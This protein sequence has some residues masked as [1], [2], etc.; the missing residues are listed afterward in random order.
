M[1]GLADQHAKRLLERKIRKSRWALLCERVWPRLWLPIGVIGIF[2]L[3]SLFGVW[4]LLPGWGHKTLLAFF[5]V[6]LLTSLFPLVALPWPSRKEA[7]RRLELKSN[8]KHRPVS[9]YEDSLAG[10]MV[11]HTT[12]RIWKIH[13]ARLLSIFSKLKSGWPRPKTERYDP[14]ALRVA[15]VLVLTLVFAATHD[16]AYDRIAAAFNNT[17]DVKPL[18]LRLD[19]WITP[20]IYTGKAPILLADGAHPLSQNDQENRIIQVPEKSVLIVRLNGPEKERFKVGL[21]NANATELEELTASDQKTD[22]NV[23]EHKIILNKPVEVDVSDGLKSLFSWR[24]KVLADRPPTIKLTQPVSNTPR[25]AISLSYRAED[26]YGV[27]GAIARFQRIMPS[28]AGP[29]VKN[30]EDRPLGTPPEMPLTLKRANLKLAE[31]RTYKDLTAHPWAGSVVHMTLVARDE[32][33]QTSNNKPIKVLLPQRNFTK[34]LAKAIV[35][36]RGKLV[37]RPLSHKSIVAQALDALTIAPETFIEDKVIYLGLRSAYWR[38]KYDN[39]RSGSESVANQL[40]ELAVRIEDGDLSDA[41]RALKTAQDQLMKALAENAPEAEIKRLMDELR[42]ALGRFLQALAKKNKNRQALSTKDNLNANRILSSKDLERILRNIENLSKTGSKDA[43]QRLLSELRDMLEGL[44]AG[45][46]Q[47]N[48]Q[49]QQMMSL[50]DELGDLV[51]RQQKLLD[52]T[53]QARR[54]SQALR[55]GQGPPRGQRR[56]QG[57]KKTPGNGKNQ[58]TGQSRQG[59]SGTRQAGPLGKRQEDLRKF[60]DRM[61]ENMRNLGAKPPDQLEGAGQAMGEA[62]KALGEKN[63]DRAVQQQTLALNRLRQGAQSMAQQIMRSMSAQYGR[64]RRD[65]FG[66]PQKSSGPELGTSVKVPDEIDVQ[67]AREILDELRKRFG[68]PMRPPVEL[69]YIERLLRR[70]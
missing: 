29:P 37:M 4:P 48:A 51:S 41:E 54:Q 25:G 62:R 20:P 32:A 34:P 43:A 39:S 67:R 21:R 70:F 66:R 36:Q 40:W 7:L 13:R 52:D 64:G 18:M 56:G 50:M 23:I 5:A 59:S 33:G 46:A 58:G 16:K 8:L 55:R 69:D 26:D 11:S 30:D 24:F 10:H 38:L 65:P 47:H 2:I 3:S 35:E 28:E 6:A 45:M 14:F 63:L 12:E 22:S 49:T 19:A 42:N 9:S 60:L 1:D 27:V 53:F 44:Q 15:L 61:L 68:E 17:P 31:G 57:K